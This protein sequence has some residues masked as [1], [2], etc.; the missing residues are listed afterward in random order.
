[1]LFIYLFPPKVY[2]YRRKRRKE[3]SGREKYLSL[4]TMRIGEPKTDLQRL[5][6]YYLEDLKGI[7]DYESIPKS[8]SRYVRPA[9]KLLGKL[10]IE[11]AKAILTKLSETMKKLEL[12]WE[13]ETILKERW[14]NDLIYQLPKNAEQLKKIEEIRQAFIAGHCL[15]E[16]KFNK[17]RTECDEQT[18][19]E[20][21]RDK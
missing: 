5:I 21:R 18:A 2:N 13:I 6:N 12:D 7:H 19:R 20:M 14:W 10:G 1:M 15:S 16:N 3:N 9:K 4:K 11:D 8:Y 17:L